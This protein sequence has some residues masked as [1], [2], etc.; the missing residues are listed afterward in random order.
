L[1]AY[2]DSSPDHIRRQIWIVS[3]SRSKRSAI[4]GKGMPRPFASASFQAAPMPSQALPPDST[5][6]VV[7]IFASI[8]G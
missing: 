2:E 1:P 4:G 7:T 5:S 8:P 3:S 6:S